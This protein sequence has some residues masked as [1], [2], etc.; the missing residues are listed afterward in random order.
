MKL[1]D[2][3]NNRIEKVSLSHRRIYS[4]IIINAKPE[5][6]WDV[7]IDTNSYE[8][9][10]EFLINIQGEIENNSKIE[11]TF[12]LDPTKKKYNKIE[13][14]ILVKKGEEYYWAEK[15]PLGI[16]DNHHFKVELFEGDKTRFIQTDELKKGATW[17]LGGY[18]SKIYLKG[19]NDFNNSLKKEVERRD[20]K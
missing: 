17:L 12:Q 13:H 4:E 19:Y 10:A 15:G 14:T 16:W 1:N 9:W 8:N 11:A 5:K 7:L 6:V 3:E 20:N 18:L 2:I